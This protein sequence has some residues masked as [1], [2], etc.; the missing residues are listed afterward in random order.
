[1]AF[2][3]YCGLSSRRFSTDL[4]ESH[5]R[6][7]LSKPIPG[8]K[9]TAFFEDAYFTPILK[10]LV[11]YSARPLRSVESAFAIDS[12][13]FGSSR[14]ER[15][16]D[17][18]YGVTRNK[19]VWGSE[20]PST[21]ASAVVFSDRDCGAEAAGRALRAG[22]RSGRGSGKRLPRVRPGSSL[23]RFARGLSDPRPSPSRR[24]CLL[25]TGEEGRYSLPLS[26]SS[27]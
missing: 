19:C 16:F 9:V 26:G 11:G 25:A 27:D 10:E 2:K 17:K 21:A 24:S 8:P 1:M 23:P 15:W 13:G 3:V 18:K 4:L 20:E 22:D 14:Y 5:E 7:F 12:S 6:G